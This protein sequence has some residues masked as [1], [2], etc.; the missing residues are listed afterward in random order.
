[1]GNEKAPA[2]KTGAFPGEF[3]SRHSNPNI[4]T[5]AGPLNPCRIFGKRRAPSW[6]SR[7]PMSLMPCF[8]VDQAQPEGII[9]G[10]LLAGY[11]EIENA[12]MHVPDCGRGKH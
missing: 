12:S 10:R 5:L 9:I 7:R 1:M 6:S 11:G 4:L 3:E 8:D 2:G